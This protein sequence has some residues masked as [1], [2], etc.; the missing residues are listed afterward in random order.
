MP[1]LSSISYFSNALLPSLLF[2]CST[3]KKMSGRNKKLHRK[4]ENTGIT[5]GW[6]AKGQ[7]N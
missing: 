7:K 6:D 3:D 2:T 1:C 4:S 5:N